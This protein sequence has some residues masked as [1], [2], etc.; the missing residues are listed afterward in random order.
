MWGCV[1]P[2]SAIGLAAALAL[3]G[4]AV[5][6]D[7]PARVVSMNLCTDQLAMLVAA[8]GQLVSIS[9]LAAN[10]M[11]SAMPE[12]ARAYPANTG[13][14]EEIF[15]MR[16]DLVLAGTYS[17]PA[18]V[19]MLERLGI[20]VAR[21][22]LTTRLDEVPERL[23]EAGRLLGREARAEALAQTFVRDLARL[24]RSG[25]PRPLAA[26]FYAN[27]YTQ[28]KGTLSDDILTHAG[29]SNLA[30]SGQ[31]A[32]GRSGGFDLALEELVMADPDLL[33]LSRP[34]PKTSRAEEILAHPALRALPAAAAPALSGPDWVCGTPLVLD[35]LAEMTRRRDALTAPPGQN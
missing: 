14:A 17:N 34:Y 28:G 35:A 9:D 19:A 7:P 18:T 2:S 33:I 22:G 1:P 21:I 31:A 3:A 12:A 4:A 15:L 20:R 32:R 25:P 6:A 13:G 5:L 26:F 29:F 30:G 11:N 23:R 24:T 16:P 8:P 27:G 10:P